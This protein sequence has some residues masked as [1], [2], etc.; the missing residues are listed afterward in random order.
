MTV[1]PITKV[2]VV[3]IDKLPRDVLILYTNTHFDI[4]LNFSWI[5]DAF[6]FRQS[7]SGWLCLNQKLFV[8][9]YFEIMHD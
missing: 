8:P 4:R 7:F 1:R 3:D 2:F 6:I 9:I 5:F